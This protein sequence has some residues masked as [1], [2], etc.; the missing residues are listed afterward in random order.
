MRRMTLFKFMIVADSM[1]A[2]DVQYWISTGFRYMLT[3]LLSA[4][5]PS[6]FWVESIISVL[7]PISFGGSEYCCGRGMR[8]VAK[9]YLNRK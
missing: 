9:R 2:P 8:A 5:Y 1:R 7:M 4:A 3:L 6:R